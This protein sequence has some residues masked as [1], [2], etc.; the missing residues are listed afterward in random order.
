MS[1]FK[2]GDLVI[3]SGGD[4]TFEGV[5]VSAFTKLSGVQRYVVEDSRGILHIYSAPNLKLQEP[6]D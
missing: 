3:K 6:K 5:I 1:E 4:Y 2:Q